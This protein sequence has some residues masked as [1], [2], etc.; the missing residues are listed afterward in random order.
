MT[1]YKLIGNL[2]GQRTLVEAK[3][4]EFEALRLIGDKLAAERCREEAHT[5]LDAW[6]DGQG[7]LADDLRRGKY[8]S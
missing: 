4:K 8:A 6:F 2:A 7:E 5:V 3:M 1:P